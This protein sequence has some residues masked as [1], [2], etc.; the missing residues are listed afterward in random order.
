MTAFN[1][2]DYPL[3]HY[4][5]RGGGPSQ[6][7]PNTLR[8]RL[9]RSP[10]TY[11][12]LVLAVI[13][14]IWE[15]YA[16]AANMLL[17]PTFSDTVLGIFTLVVDPKTWTAF[18][19][20]NQ[21]LVIGFTI[22][23]IMGILLGLGAARFRSIEGFVDP[24]LSIL[25]VTPMAALIP[26]LLMSLG[27][28]LSSRVALVIVFSIP[29]IIVNSR[30][31]VRQVDPNLIEM[32][33]SFGAGERA[34]WTKILLPGALPAIMTGIRLGLGRGV[35]GMVIIELLMIAVGIGSLILN[36]QGRFEADLLYALV[37]LVIF[38]ALLLVSA[39]RAI[40]RR[41]APWANQTVLR[42]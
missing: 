18:L 7:T 1:I 30:T 4:T 6:G 31:G 23:V 14:T 22:S 9:L 39:L 34:I 20:S 15:V 13:G 33:T 17:I 26:I 10:W 25:L 2:Q 21:A 35:T 11:R 29:V 3:K 36:F 16:R 41:V 8:A 37:V 32:A 27:I 40:E 12:L 28:E 5:P 19:I 42:E 38:E 24:Y